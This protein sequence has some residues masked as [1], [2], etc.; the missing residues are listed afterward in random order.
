MTHEYASRILLPEGIGHI[1]ASTVRDAIEAIV[2]D[3]AEPGE[4]VHVT[5]DG[6]RELTLVLRSEVE[7]GDNAGTLLIDA[8][9]DVVRGCLEPGE[10]VEVSPFEARDALG[11]IPGY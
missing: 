6:E 9:R 3:G 1:A 8:V 5:Q 11:S 10:T 2:P 7:L 4:E